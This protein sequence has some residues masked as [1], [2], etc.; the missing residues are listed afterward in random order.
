MSLDYFFE[1]DYIPKEE[2]T[3]LSPAF[4]SYR[5]A[6]GYSNQND[7]KN[8]LGGKDIS[9]SIDYGYTLAL[10]DRVH[11]IIVKINEI[12]DED[13]RIKDINDFSTRHI[14]GSFEKIRRANLLHKLNNQGRRVEEVLFSWLKGYAITEYFLPSLKKIFGQE[15]KKIGEDD[16]ENIETFKRSARADLEVEKNQMKL[17]LEIQAGFQGTNDIKEHKILEA[18]RIFKENNTRTIGIHFDIYNGQVAFLQLES[19]GE[20]SNWVA[21]KQMEGQMVLE[22][23]PKY[24]KWKLNEKIPDEN[25]LGIIW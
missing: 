11:E 8:F 16:L 10:V 4:R 15:I 17:R 21:R 20:D 2:S 9:P 7:A 13:S 14:Y 19:M 24:F 5:T 1:D 18:K 12:I 22:I 3:D 6:L 25:A 23:E